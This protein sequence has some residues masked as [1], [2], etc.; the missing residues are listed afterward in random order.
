[1]SAAAFD[2]RKSDP[3]RL[4][5]QHL[6]AAHAA[7]EGRVDTS[8]FERLVVDAPPAGDGQV[9]WQA[10]GELR[11]VSGGPPE[12]WLHLRAATVVRMVCQRCL[13]PLEQPLSVARSFR[14]VGDETLA[15]R[16]DEDSEDDVLALP[17]RGRLDL[18]ALVEDELILAL[19]LVPRHESCPDPLPMAAEAPVEEAPRENPFAALAALKK[20]AR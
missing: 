5:L 14:F 15:E 17:P 6:A 12:T 11:P 9:A 3:R 19:P 20:Q 7:V 4:D 2:P 16:L 13:Q 8:A 10:R 18:P 1:M